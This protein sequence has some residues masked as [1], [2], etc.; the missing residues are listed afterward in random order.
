MEE[1]KDTHKIVIC[2]APATGKSSLIQ[3]LSSKGFNTFEEV[4]REIIQDQIANKSNAV[5]WEDLNAFS[6]LVLAGRIQHFKAANNELQFFDRGLP[7]SSAYYFLSN[8]TVPSEI[9]QACRLHRYN[10][11][12][13]I[14]PPWKEIYCTD[15]ERKESFEDVLKLHNAIKEAYLRYGYEVCEIPKGSL[16]ERFQFISQE[17]NLAHAK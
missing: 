13:F 7:D 5:P 2:G 14:C 12:V 1:Y 8:L 17:L 15:N 10:Q 3:H 11:K 16:E 6:K 4:S 9:D